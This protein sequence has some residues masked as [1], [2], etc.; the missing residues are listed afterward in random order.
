MPTDINPLPSQQLLKNTFRYDP[1]TG[2]FYW[3]KR[4]GNKAG[5]DGGLGYI[6]IRFQHT[7]YL[8]HRLAWMY[9]YGQDPGSKRVDHINRDPSDNRIGNLRLAEVSE[10]TQ[11]QKEM[12]SRKG[13]KLI[14]K[15]KGVYPCPWGWYVS[16]MANGNKIYLGTFKVEQ[17]AINAYLEA[18]KKYHK[19]FC[20]S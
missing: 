20:S 1:D 5:C 13:K 7:I 15:H 3:I 11:N 16:L 2:I 19:E 8:A 12:S 14:R 17:E 9:H 6:M 10:N 4:N 18:A